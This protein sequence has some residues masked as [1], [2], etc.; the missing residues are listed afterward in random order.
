VGGLFQVADVLNLERN[1]MP[2]LHVAFAFTLAAAF[3][4]RTGRAGGVVLFAWAVATALSTLLTR[5]HNLLDVAGGLMLAAIAWPLALRWGR[6]P[7]VVA[8]VDVELLCLRNCGAFIARHRR[9]LVITLAVMAAGIPHWRRQRLVRTGF[10]FLQAVD[11]IVDGDRASEREPLEVV[12]ELIVALEA[13][14]SRR[15]SSDGS[16]RHFALTCSHGVGPRR[17]QRP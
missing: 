9:Y 7:G 13:A 16:A 11:D 6:R 10:V 14:S 15:M 17:W 4:A 5:Q 1:D 2:S 8:A 3:S 12:D